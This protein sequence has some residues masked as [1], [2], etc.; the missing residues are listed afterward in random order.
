MYVLYF[1]LLAGVSLQLFCTLELAVFM[2]LPPV[3]SI[4]CILT[5]YNCSVLVVLARLVTKNSFSLFTSKLPSQIE[6]SFCQSGI[7]SLY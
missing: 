3:I 1:L 7:F 4:Y 6:A 2:T 5:N